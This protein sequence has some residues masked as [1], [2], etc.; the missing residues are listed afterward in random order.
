MI[1]KNENK[2]L[3]SGVIGW[4]GNWLPLLFDGRSTRSGELK[5]KMVGEK[6]TI[7]EKKYLKTKQKIK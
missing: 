4:F 7:G 3:W 1:I 5:K 6:K 2:I